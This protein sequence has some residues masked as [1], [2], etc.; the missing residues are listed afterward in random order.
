MPVCDGRG[1]SGVVVLS[2]SG[3]VAGRGGDVVVG[4]AGAGARV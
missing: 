1:V 2:D 4:V 3:V